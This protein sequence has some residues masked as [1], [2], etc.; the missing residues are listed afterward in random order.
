MCLQSCRN[1]RAV[2]SFQYHLISVLQCYEPVEV[3]PNRFCT[4]H[5]AFSYTAGTSLLVFL[6]VP[7]HTHIS[8]LFSLGGIKPL[9]K[10]RSLLVIN[11]ISKKTFFAAVQPHSAQKGIITLFAWLV[12]SGSPCKGH[13]ACMAYLL[14]PFASKHPVVNLYIVYLM[15][16]ILIKLLKFKYMGTSLTNQNYMHE[17][18]KAT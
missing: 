10:D 3:M 2:S 1:K 16:R 17:E 12:L 11:D 18:I 5:F 14:N 15:K 13:S 4:V 8:F 7:L 6:H 9:P